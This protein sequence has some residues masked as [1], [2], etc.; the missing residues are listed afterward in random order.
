MKIK[1]PFSLFLILIF[2]VAKAAAPPNATIYYPYPWCTGWG[3]LQ[4]I[5]EGT[6]GGTFSATPGLVIN[7]VT[8]TISPG[9][10]AAGTFTVNYTI[11]STPEDPAF[12]CTT[13]V[14][15]LPEM[16]PMFSFPTN[17]CTE[18]QIPN[19]PVTSDNGITGTWSPAINN[20]FTTTYTFTPD[21][22]QC[23][24]TTSITI[25]IEDTIQPEFGF[26]GNSFCQGTAPT[27]PTTSLNGITGSW[28]PSVVTTSGAYTFT[29]DAGQCA[30]PRTDFFTVNPMPTVTI[31]GSTTVC[32]GQSATVNF[33]GT[34]NA[35]VTYTYNSGPMQMIV[36]NASGTATIVTPALSASSM[37]CLVSVTSSGILNCTTSLS[38][39]AVINVLPPL[40]VMPMPD[41]TVCDQYTLPPLQ[42]GNY[43]LLSGGNG[44]M[45]QAGDVI[46]ASSMIYVYLSNSCSSVED[47]FQ[48][49]VIP[50]TIPVIATDNN[51]DYIY[52]DGNQVA[53]T[54]LLNATMSGNYS[55]QWALF[56]NDILGANGP[57]YLVNTTVQG[58][59]SYTVKVTH[60][61]G[62]CTTESSEFHVFE[63]PVPAPVGD[64]N[65]T[66]TLGQ[67]LADVVVYGQNIQWYDSLNRGTDSTPLPLNTVLQEGVTYYATQTINGHESPSAFSITIQF[68]ATDS[69]AFRDLKF[70]PNPVRDFLQLSSKDLIQRI[71]VLNLMGQKVLQHNVNTPDF[72]L[73]M[74]QLRT[75]NYFVKLESDNKSQVIKIIKE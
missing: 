9:Q 39:C 40:V 65:Q 6:T 33:N 55:Y 37:F 26:N 5:L 35:L 68:L 31:S 45:L 72:S 25:F 54:L 63:T 56:G 3:D 24:T 22:S 28:N 61:M 36:L 52:V 30:I 15:I 43:Y 51:V 46:T 16:I 73:P 32:Q 70:A 60:L 11:A 21:A 66:F 62:G 58:V 18:S 7:P 14:V 8:G 1:L 29:P 67:T 44:P 17:Y 75:G 71:T 59:H 27:L 13:T 57:T 12:V 20:Q 19:F 2:S 42:Q 41:V 64:P 47:A 74:S 23:A 53:Q 38:G 50:T 48:V 69:F 34:P 10:S 49:T 4:V